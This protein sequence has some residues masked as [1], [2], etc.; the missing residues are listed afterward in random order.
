MSS[1]AGG[2][3]LEMIIAAEFCFPW[4]KERGW[5]R[6]PPRVLDQW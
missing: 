1:C 2:D 4:L 3:E 5:T 6:F